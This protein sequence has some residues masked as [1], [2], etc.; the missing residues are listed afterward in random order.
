M[1][2]VGIRGE[3]LLRSERTGSYMPGTCDL[4]FNLRMAMGGTSVEKTQTEGSRVKCHLRWRSYA[5]LAVYEPKGLIDSMLYAKWPKFRKFIKIPTVGHSLTGL[6]I[7]WF[8]VCFMEP[9]CYECW[10][11]FIHWESLVFVGWLI[12]IHLT[13]FSSSLIMSLDF[14]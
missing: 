2:S 12:S 9:P 6:P 8:S 4:L 13:T 10:V 5:I 11:W 1:S 14:V 7:S 3:S